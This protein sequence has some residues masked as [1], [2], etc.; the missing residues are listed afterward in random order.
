MFTNSYRMA[1]V[2]PSVLIFLITNVQKE[3]AKLKEE[4]QENFRGY[5]KAV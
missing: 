2:F 5:L 4:C 1:C 3:I